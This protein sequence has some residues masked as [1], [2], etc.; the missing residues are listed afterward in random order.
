MNSTKRYLTI[1][2]SNN[3]FSFVGLLNSIKKRIGIEFVFLFILFL[4]AIIVTKGYTI[5]WGLVPLFL[6]FPYAKNTTKLS[7][8]KETAFLILLFLIVFTINFVLVYNFHHHYLPT[9]SPLHL[10][11]LFSYPSRFFSSLLLFFSVVVALTFHRN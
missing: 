10:Y 5:A 3:A 11:L 4:F 7:S 1:S 2:N 6:V 9:H 8:K